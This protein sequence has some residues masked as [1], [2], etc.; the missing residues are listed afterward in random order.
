[1]SQS[2]FN[3]I[4]HD[5]RFPALY[6][7]SELLCLLQADRQQ[8]ADSSSFVNPKCHSTVAMKRIVISGKACVWIAQIMHDKNVVELC[9]QSDAMKNQN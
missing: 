4:L 6:R 1:V 9:I 5:S 7:R 2:L 8:L 3:G